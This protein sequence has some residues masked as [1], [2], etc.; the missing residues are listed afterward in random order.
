MDWSDV[1]IF[2]AVARAGSLGG[3]ARLTGQSQPTMGRR[4]RVLE[5]EVG[6]ALFQR[7]KDG[8]V[9]TDEGASVLAHSERMEEEALAFERR[10]AGQAQQ[11]EGLLRVSS[12]D[13]FGVHILTPVFAEFVRQHPLVN[14][15]LI[16]DAR[17]FSLARREADLVFRIQPF[18]EAD[19]VQRKAVHVAYRVY[20]AKG[21]AHPVRSD[22]QGVP[23]ITLDSAFQDFPDA[24]WL[25]KKLPK[26]RVAFGSNSREAQARMCAAGVGLAV[27]P[28][29][30]GDACA[31]LEVVD[32]GGLPPGRDVWVGFHRDLR[33]LGRLRALV[34]ATVERLSA[35]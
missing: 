31:A 32:L 1:K 16:T 3:A 34:D 15:E 10:L 17:L 24:A 12:S 6:Q 21:T 35:S 13:W 25:R 33:R 7:G 5:R 26:A 14:I 29:P 2:L 23:L 9:L 4:L 11:L 28:A 19:V 22:G 20:R 30:L 27:L 8:F 18:D